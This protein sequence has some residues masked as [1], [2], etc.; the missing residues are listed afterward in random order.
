[1]SAGQAQLTKLLEAWGQG[2]SQALDELTPFIYIELRKLAQFHTPR[3]AA[4]RTL[5]PTALINDA[6]LKLIGIQQTDWRGQK[7]FYAGLRKL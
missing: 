1:M 4:G 2:D 5:Q 6:F 7:H 3:E